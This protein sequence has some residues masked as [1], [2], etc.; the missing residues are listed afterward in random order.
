M[1]PATRSPYPFLIAINVSEREL[2]RVSTVTTTTLATAVHTV[3]SENAQDTG[4]VRLGIT[5]V[6]TESVSNTA[7]IWHCASILNL[8]F[9]AE[10]VNY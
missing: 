4:P 8:Y 1:K 9:E 6:R 5:G 7:T 10:F 3:M 2:P